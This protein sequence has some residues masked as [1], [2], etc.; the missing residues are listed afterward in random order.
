M[1]L[2][3]EALDA[4]VS[5]AQVDAAVNS[6]LSAN[7]PKAG[8]NA[9]DAQVAAA[10]SA[11][12]NANPP[13]PGDNATAAQ[14]STAVSAY[15]AANPIKNGTNGTNATDAQVAS[16]VTAYLLAN[17]VKNGVDGIVPVYLNGT[18]QAN[19]QRQSFDTTT[20][21]NGNWK[22]DFT[23]AK[24]KSVI[25]ITAT[26]WKDI[27][28]AADQVDVR[29]KAFTLTQVTGSVVK[30]QK[31]TSLLITNGADAVVKVGAGIALRVVIEGAV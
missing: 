4:E 25:E 24:F 8:Q 11:Y 21:A 28:T 2:I 7:P 1:T 20:D 9:T 23:A 5:Q 10:V 26:A 14:I 6:Y 29:Y 13:K 18:L 17:P 19:V 12:L 16:A 3:S 15:I 30:P 22:V 31:I 27:D